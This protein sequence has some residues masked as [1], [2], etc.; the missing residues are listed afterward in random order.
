MRANASRVSSRE[1]SWPSRAWL[2][3]SLS[4]SGAEYMFSTVFRT[5]AWRAGVSAPATT[6]SA[7]PNAHAAPEIFPFV[8]ACGLIKSPP[9]EPAIIGQSM[10]QV[11]PAP[12][13]R[14]GMHPTLRHHP[15]DVR[16]RHV[17]RIARG[18]SDVRY[19]LLVEA[20]AEG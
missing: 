17:F 6:A 2:T 3:T 19:N 10:G 16:L 4:G 1:T 13:N 15:L 11:N 9:R 5:T 14:P 12:Y 7:S 8:R 20:E 18:A